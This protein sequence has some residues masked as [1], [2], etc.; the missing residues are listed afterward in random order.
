MGRWIVIACLLAAGAALADATQAPAPPGQ[1]PPPPLSVFQPS[2]AAGSWRHLQSG[3]ICPARMGAYLR[4]RVVVFDQYGL[5]VGCNY[6]AGASD[7][8]VYLTRR[9]GALGDVMADAKRGLL[10][11]GA[12]RHPALVSDTREAAAGLTWLTAIYAEDGD[13]HSG[14]W[15]ADLSGWTLEYRA[16]YAAT[17]EADVFADIDRFTAEVQASAAPRLA[18]CARS[19]PPPRGAAMIT[20]RKD[21]EQSSMMT[22]ILGGAALAAAHQGKGKAG[23][24][25]TWC[26]EAPIAK[27]DVRFLFW[28]AVNPDGADARF[29]RLTAMTQ[30]EPPT[31][32]LDPDEMAGLVAANSGHGAKTIRW[33]AAVRTGDHV[34]IFAYFDGRPDADAAADLLADILAGKVKPVGGYGANGKN[35][36]IEMAPAS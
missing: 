35:I 8:T 24:E 13:L 1:P 28:R 9:A 5:D 11:V 19:A 16:T 25:F 2:D 7:I 32:A 36:T 33:T 34:S 6:K 31:L 15:I 30:G 27:G 12:S 29:D 4:T 3:L 18:L 17:S 14:I 10:Q 23:L 21:L 20:D 26:P 22:S